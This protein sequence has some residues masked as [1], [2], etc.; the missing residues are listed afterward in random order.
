MHTVL[1]LVQVKQMG[2]QRSGFDPTPVVSARMARVRGADT[3]A[4]VLLRLALWKRG[5][6]YFKN[7]RIEGRRVDVVFPTQ[8]VAI[9][10]DG[11]FWH[12]CP[13]HANLPNKNRGYW[14]AKFESIGDRDRQDSK[15]LISNGWRVIRVWEHEILTSPEDVA[16]RI[17]GIIGD[18]DPQVSRC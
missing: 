10:V 4:E 1:P 2:L 15:I 12:R 9:F 3:R 13:V 17:V 6:R 18:G 14:R 16:R 8:R 11:C 5:A 7:R